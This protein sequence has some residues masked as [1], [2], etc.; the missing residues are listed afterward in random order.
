LL[1]ALGNLLTMPQHWNKDLGRDGQSEP[2]WVNDCNGCR[3]GLPLQ[4]AGYVAA[5]W[6][7]LVDA[8]PRRDRVVW[9][10]AESNFV[11][12]LGDL[13]GITFEVAFPRPGSAK[14]KSIV[15]TA[16]P[17]P[18]DLPEAF[19]LTARLTQRYRR[20]MDVFPPP[21]PDELP[22]EWMERVRGEMVAKV[23]AKQCSIP[24]M[25]PIETLPQAPVLPPVADPEEERKKME[26]AFAQMRLWNNGGQQ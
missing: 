1:R 20:T 11:D 7:H 23:K 25:E 15:R 4:K 12:L 10:I 5:E 22:S 17:T 19:D 16:R 2:H 8:K 6:L 14:M 9:P 26:A 13:R 18:T 21:L 24:G 3:T